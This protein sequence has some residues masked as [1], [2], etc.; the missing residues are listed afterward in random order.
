[1]A[2]TYSYTLRGVAAALL[3]VV[4]S[5][6]EW[7]EVKLFGAAGRTRVRDAISAKDVNGGHN[8]NKNLWRIL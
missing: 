3:I 8:F 6:A 7:Q 2:D 5:E 1:M 4:C